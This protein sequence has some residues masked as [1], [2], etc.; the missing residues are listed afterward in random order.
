MLRVRRNR[1][2]A[3]ITRWTCPRL[4]NV[5]AWPVSMRL[6]RCVAPGVKPRPTT[7]AR[8]DRGKQRAMC[9]SRPILLVT[10]PRSALQ[11]VALEVQ[12]RAMRLFSRDAF[13]FATFI[14]LTRTLYRCF[15]AFCCLPTPSLLYFALFE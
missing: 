11:P 3:R 1:Q 2:R 5:F 8:R 15:I 12:D 14:R 6:P 4:R 9:P 13:L 7:S 10:A